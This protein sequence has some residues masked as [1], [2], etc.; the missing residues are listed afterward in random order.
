LEHN[1][2]NLFLFSVSIQINQKKADYTI[3]GNLNNPYMWQK[4]RKI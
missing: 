1:I 2:N 3:F 4:C